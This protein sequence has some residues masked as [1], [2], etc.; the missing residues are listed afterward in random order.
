MT[1]AR[2]DAAAAVPAALSHRMTV[3]V[4]ALAGAAL[5]FVAGFA[6]SE[7]LHAAAHDTRHAVGFPCH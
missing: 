3:L 1:N 5:L 6:P 4:L 7:I 2:L